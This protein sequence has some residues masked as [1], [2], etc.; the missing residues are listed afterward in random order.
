VCVVEASS[1]QLETVERFRP[2]VAI[3]LNVTPD[4]LDRYPDLESY[5][6]AKARIFSAQTAGDFAVVNIDDPLADRLTRGLASH[7]MPISTRQPLEEGGWVRGNVLYVRLPGGELEDYPADLPALVGRHNQENA[8]AA[9]LAARLG[10]ALVSE[11]RR[12]LL[13]FRP[14]AHRM[15]LVAESEGVA[16][17]DDSKGTNVGAVVAA[18]SGFPRPVILIAGGRDKG[19][20]YEPLAGALK[21]VGRGAVLIGE[22]AERMRAALSGVL[23]VEMATSMEDAVAR[24]TAMAQSGDAVVL[25]PACSSFDMFRNYEHRAEVFRAAVNELVAGRDGVRSRQEAR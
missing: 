2:Q 20:S 18:L 11:A 8:L 17:F 7:R 23:P 14:L 1:F 6:R 5:G 21:E 24:A 25:S 3:L 10:G 15:E 22:A 16:F 4:H 9:L 19:G 13:A 12:A